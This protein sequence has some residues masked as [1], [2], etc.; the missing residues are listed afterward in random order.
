MG[1]K[2]LQ[3]IDMNPEPLSKMDFSR[4]E[5]NRTPVIKGKD[6]VIVGLQPWYFE[7]GCNSKDIAIRLAKHNRVLYVNFPHKRIAYRAKKPDP[8]IVRH[9][10]IIKD[11]Q[12]KI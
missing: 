1:E 2:Q 3:R 10:N 6:I 9:I 7:T 4:I 8:K 5:K 12:E 11:K